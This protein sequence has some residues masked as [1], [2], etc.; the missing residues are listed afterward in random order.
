MNSY[1]LYELSWLSSTLNTLSISC[2]FIIG[3]K[4]NPTLT[5]DSRKSKAAGYDDIPAYV[6]GKVLTVSHVLFH[7]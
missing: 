5:L 1:N 4:T 3:Q 6:L 2:Y 7:I